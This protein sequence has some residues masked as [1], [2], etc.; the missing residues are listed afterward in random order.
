[1]TF[2][3]FRRAFVAAMAFTVAACGDS[4]VALDADLTTAQVDEMMDAMSAVGAFSS[5]FGFSVQSLNSNVA[6]VVTPINESADCPN[7][8]S[9]NSA[10]NVNINENTGNFTAQLTNNYSNCK[11]TS[12]AGRVWTFNGDPNITQTMTFTSNQTTGAFQMSGSQ[13]GG[14]RFSSSEATGRCSINL[15]YTVSFDAE[16]AE[17]GSVTGTVCGQSVN[18]S[19]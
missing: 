7:G 3:N 4:P 16:G 9:V 11:A 14:L 12:S 6:M 15:N 13:T 5:P 1:M 2:T 8:G 10:G 17:T 19:L 18:H